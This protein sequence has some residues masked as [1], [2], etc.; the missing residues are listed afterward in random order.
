V[1]FLKKF[2]NLFDNEEVTE[3]WF[4][5]GTLTE[6]EMF[7]KESFSNRILLLKSNITNLS[8]H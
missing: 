6:K 2:T 1:P 3:T 4:F 7:A 5:Y 8:S